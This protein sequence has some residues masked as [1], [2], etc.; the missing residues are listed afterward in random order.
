MEYIT[1]K[2]ASKK[3]GI[4]T[5]RI[6]LLANEGRI[7]GA[8]RLGKSWLIPASA[9]K[10]AQLKPSRTGANKNSPDNF[11]FPLYHFRSDWNIIK[12]DEL[13]TQQ[14]ILLQ[15]ET[16]VLECRFSDA[17]MLLATIMKSSDDIAIEI[18]SL[19][20]AGLCCIALNKPEEYIRINLRLQMLLSDDFPHRD[21]LVIILD[22]LKTYIETTEHSANGYT[23]NLNIHKQCLPMVC[24]LVGFT[25]YA[26]ESVSPGSAD[27]SIL[28]LIL[29]FLKSTGSDIAMQFMHCHLLAIYDMRQEIKKAELHAK[30][31]VQIAFENGFYLPLATYYPYYR[32]VFD[33]V[34]AEYPED[35]MNH[36]QNLYTQ[37]KENI[38]DF[39]L[40]IYENTVFANLSNEDYPFTNGVYMG[41]TNASIAEK[42]GISTNTVN[43]RIEKI[44]H[45]LNAENKKELQKY[46]RNYM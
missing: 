5:S 25:G 28:E 41:L 43:R 44:C 11:S 30:E 3:W 29:C 16:A 7:P 4:S 45:K 24:A 18:G 21:D 46:L 23:Y 26:K 22:F 14:Q 10:P 17:Y 6:T 8:Y 13:S 19:G 42:L 37:N 40:S 33:L 27:I 2:E 36:C 35:F 32:N 38:T 34:L 9:T 31:A 15:A 20:L 39:L 1:T 12:T